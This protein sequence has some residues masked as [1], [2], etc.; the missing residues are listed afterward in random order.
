MQTILV[1]PD[2]P[3]TF[4]QLAKQHMET[5]LLYCCLK[6][7][8]DLTLHSLNTMF[9]NLTSMLVGCVFKPRMFCQM[10]RSY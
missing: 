1:L 9:C 5:V 2:F 8:K 6:R 7:M 10:E 4:L 3:E